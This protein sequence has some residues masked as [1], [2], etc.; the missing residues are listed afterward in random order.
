MWM[1]TLNIIH[2]LRGVIKLQSCRSTQYNFTSRAILEILRNG[3]QSCRRVT[4]WCHRRV[5]FF[6]ASFLPA[7]KKRKKKRKNCVKTFSSFTFTS[8]RWSLL[9][10]SFSIV[11]KVKKDAR[12]EKWTV[13]K[14]LYY[15]CTRYVNSRWQFLNTLIIQNNF[16]INL[17]KLKNEQNWE[18]IH[19]A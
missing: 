8:P 9:F 11:P 3:L 5:P 17:S 10:F 4:L 2:F 14:H 7:K 19:G 1:L 13:A 6:R 16:C 18:T 12:L 15:N